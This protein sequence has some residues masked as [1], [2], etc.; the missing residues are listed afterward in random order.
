MRQQP[1][2][3]FTQLIVVCLLCL[4]LIGC[5]QQEQPTPESQPEPNPRTLKI[6]LIPE[7]D[8]FTQK[9]RYE[10]LLAQ[11][12]K[13]LDVS[14]EVSILPRYGNIID[15]FNELGL[16]GAFFG[17]F[18][19]AMAIKKLGVEPLARPQYVG[20]ASTYYGIVF[21]KKGSGIRTAEDLRGKQMA[22][23]DR[24]TTA[25]YLLPLAYFQSLGIDDYKTWFKEYYFSGTH[26]DAI[27]D[28][29]NGFADIGAAKNT[30]FYRLATVN[31]RISKELEILA[32]S[33][34]VPAN[35]LAVRHD[36]DNDLKQGLKQKLLEMDQ[37]AEGRQILAGLKIEKFIETT[38]EDY[39]PVLDYAASIGLD[40][41]TYNYLNN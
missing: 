39:Q 17:S 6:G 4:L 25:G 19:G 13:E 18:T 2:A 23:V 41:K 40:L 37:H 36:L 14:I 26:E 15:S 7:Q 9:K 12:A 21:V 16:D 10:P 11:L 29:L 8:V 38:K 3:V 31:S 20:G 27:N 34:H 5:S 35:G 24:A 28:V 30:V 33:P 32:T 1:T 22:F